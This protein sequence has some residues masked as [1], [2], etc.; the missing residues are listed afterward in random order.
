[1]DFW[2][3][4]PEP[5]WLARSAHPWMVSRRRFLRQK[6]HRASIGRWVLDSGGF[7][8]VSQ[9]GTWRTAPEEF[10]AQVRHIIDAVGRP[11]W[12]APQDWMC[13]PWVVEGTG[14][15]VLEHQ[16]RTVENFT[17]LRRIAPTVPWIPV[18]Q[19]FEVEDYWRC[20]EMY[21]AVGVDLWS[22]PVVGVGSVCRRQ[23]TST[24]GALLTGLAAA[25]LRLHGFGVKVTGLAAYGDSLV[26]ADSM[27]WSFAARRENIRLDGCS[28]Q[29]CSNCMRW[30]IRWTED[31]VLPIIDRVRGTTLFTPL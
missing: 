4:A 24:A 13:E 3:G 6:S 20:V 23:G 27:A 15:T 30:A 31:S 25:G 19:G 5:V 17:L 9:H 10:A 2:T 18:L 16:R 14:L 22:E 8:E 12:C 7:T 1:M 29:K 28:H 11:D 21:D 26:S